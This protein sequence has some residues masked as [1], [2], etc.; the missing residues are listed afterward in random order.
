MAD[1]TLTIPVEH[2]TR[3]IH[4]LCAANYSDDESGANAK[5]ELI[6]HIKRLVWRIE[7]QEAEAAAAITA[8]DGLVT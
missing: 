7:T 4:A 1:I 3:V 2:E 5:L 8:E 6:E